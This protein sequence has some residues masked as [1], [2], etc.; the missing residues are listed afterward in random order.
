MRHITFEESEQYPIALLIKDSSFNVREIERNYV[1]YLIDTGIEKKDIVS[2]SLAYDKNKAPVKFIKDY[3]DTLLPALET[4]GSKYLYCADAAY[5]KVLTKSTKAE[6]YLGYVLP[7]KIEGYEHFKVTLGIGYTSLIYNPANKPKMDLSLDALIGISQGKYEDLGSDIIK[8]AYYPSDIEDISAA[9]NQLHQYPSL[10]CDIETFSLRFNEA[11]IATIAF[12]WNTGEGI[13]FACDYSPFVSIQ[14][15]LH[16]TK[17]CNPYVKTLLRQFFDSYTGTL[18]WHGSSFDL[19]V[20]IYELWMQ[21]ALDTAGLLLGLTT[22]TKNFHDTKIIAYLALNSTARSSY[23][24]KALAHEFAGNWAL[25]DESIKDVRKI[26]LKDL[27]QYNL[28]DALATNYVF[29]KYYPVVQQDQQDLLYFT[30]MRP[31]LPVIIQ[32]ELTGM[33]LDPIQVQAVR[34]ELEKV[35]EEQVS[36]L[37]ASPAIQ[38]L[39]TRLQRE[40]MEAKNAKLKVKQHPIEAFAHIRFNPGSDKQLQK[41][42]Y[43]EMELPVID[44]TKGKQ[45]STGAKTISKLENH[46]DVQEYL[47]ILNAI[48]EYSKAGKILDTFIPAFEK[49]IDKEDGAVWLHGNFNLGGTVSGR[50]SSSKPNLQNLPSGSKYGK[51]IKKC[52]V[53][54]PG[55]VLVGADFSSLED[56]INAL[57]TKDPNKLRIYTDGLDS[58]SYRAYNY[59]PQKFPDVENTVESI[60]FIANTHPELRQ[61]SKTITFALTYAGTWLTLM[62]NCGF[63]EEEAKSIEANY[64]KLYQVSLQWVQDKIQE[65]S[66]KGFSEVAFGLRIRTPLLAQTL[67][68]HRTTPKE[69]QAE[70]RTLGN[71]ISGQSFGLLNNRA[72]NAF[73]AKVWNSPYC[74]DI[75]PVAQ[76]HDAQYYLIRDDIDILKWVNNELIKEMS[77]QELPEI[78]HDK[79]KLGAELEVYYSNWAQ[80][81]TIPNNSSNEEI[82]EVIK[83]GMQKHDKG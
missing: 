22:L 46:T 8:S 38:K 67:Q 79:V 31:S 83:E 62:N 81:I 21:D 49:A 68:N 17:V 7:C 54:P 6:P 80:P 75:K 2:I 57:L 65:A 11:G 43:E 13:A 56:R 25:D 58:H 3:L 18:T 42:L 78:Q 66:Q 29:D 20:L 48:K 1:N 19:K 14:E 53:P 73:M 76:I 10:A 26:P 5:F 69:A 40:A 41:L 71:A 37:S 74:C 33:P 70:A 34:D 50:L 82:R 51:L 60:N 72:A 32:M 63:S 35:V 4:I 15:G 45:P 27:L 9:L 39:E 61:K 16:G 12:A 24:L 36:I 64:Q 44:Y 55:W 30:L 23:S 59:W 28:V 77:W 52:F 47:D